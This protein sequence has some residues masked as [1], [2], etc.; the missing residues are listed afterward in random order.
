M[1]NNSFFLALSFMF[2]AHSSW[3]QPTFSISPDFQLVDQNDQVCYD[4]TT[5]DFSFLLSVSFTLAWN[6][7]VA[8]NA[9]ITP[10]NLN[11][12]M[13]GLDMSDFVINNSEGYMDL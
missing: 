4:I 10:S 7:G 12:N 8:N 2:F 3:A 11:P 1:K 5:A 13:T 9:T 6:A